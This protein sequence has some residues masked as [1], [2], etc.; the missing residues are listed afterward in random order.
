MIV[1]TST[2][3]SGTEG[4]IFRVEM[5]NDAGT[6]WK[7]SKKTLI[8]AWDAYTTVTDYDL[9]VDITLA[10]G[11]KVKFVQSAKSDYNDGDYWLW[12]MTVDMKLDED[13]AGGYTN[14]KVIENGDKK[15]LIILNKNS[16]DV[17]EIK[18]FESTTPSINE[19][20]VNIGSSNS[21]DI[22]NKN[23][24]IY[25]ARGI[26]SNP[27]WVG[28]TKNSNFDPPS[29]IANIFSDD[30]YRIIDVESTFTKILDDFVTLRGAKEADDVVSSRSAISQT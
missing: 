20:I 29:E 2:D 4:T 7:W 26:N 1:S 23:K 16:G 27:K 30:A 12:I 8:G 15:N 10:L 9:D 19:N 3:F 6:S 11:V 24:E 5:L 14:L 28:Y 21:I 22:C 13:E 25:I 17:V 18:D